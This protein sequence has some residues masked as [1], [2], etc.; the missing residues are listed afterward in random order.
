[1]GNTILDI[2]VEEAGARVART[3]RDFPT[4]R[5]EDMPHFH[6]TP[7]SLKAALRSP[8]LE[9]IAEIKKA[10]PSKG[11]IREVFDPVEIAEAYTTSGAA[12]ISVL[13]E[14]D[15]FLGSLSDLSSVRAKTTLPVLRKD[16]I[17]DPYQLSEARAFGADAVLLLAGVLDRTHLAELLLA[18]RELELSCLV[19][20]YDERELDRV[21]FDLV[22]ILGANNRDLHTFEV[23]TTRAAR[24]LSRA[25]SSVITVAES[26]LKSAEDLVGV[27][28]AGVDAVLIGETLMLEKDPGDAL[29][30][31]KEAVQSIENG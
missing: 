8:N 15:R 31:L 4:S 26:G 2:L 14:P 24:V 16:F 12:A 25:P 23:D 13:T 7:L 18:A 9:I 30:R 19:E 17:I 6:R 1:M 22:E 10:S 20:I 28:R 11:L 27:H 5:L 29:S 3:R 21:D